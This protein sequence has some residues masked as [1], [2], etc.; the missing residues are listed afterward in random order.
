MV[1]TRFQTCE[2]AAN[3]VELD[4]VEC[5]SA[6][7]GSE[8]Y[9]AAGMLPVP[10]DASGLVQYLGQRFEVRYRISLWVDV[11]SDRGKSSYAGLANFATQR[12]RLQRGVDLKWRGLSVPI[13]EMRIAT[14]AGIGVFCGV[15]VV[16]SSVKIT[17]V[18]HLAARNRMS[19]HITAR[20]GTCRGPNW[21]HF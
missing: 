4:F 16:P 13:Q 7:C 12:P 11:F 6:G 21:D 15:V 19:Q 10:S 1:D 14:D 2:V 5:S 9:F 18:S 8:I 3:C 17:V 20:R